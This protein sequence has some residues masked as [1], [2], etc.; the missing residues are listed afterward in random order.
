MPQVPRTRASKAATPMMRSRVGVAAAVIAAVAVGSWLLLAQNR[1]LAT[2]PGTGSVAHAPRPP[3]EST[4]S[5]EPAPSDAS[6]LDDML[7]AESGELTDLLAHLSETCA[8]ATRPAGARLEIP[9]VEAC[10]EDAEQAANLASLIRESVESPGGAAM[11]GDVRS[12][13]EATLTTDAG[14]VDRALAPV[15]VAVGRVLASGAAR[16]ADFRALSHLRDRIDRVHAI[17]RR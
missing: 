7:E 14:T 6:G 12:R 16:A 13:W 11:P 9:A 10:V 1:P 5:S 17:V 15:A 4:D 8:A 3:I 2:P